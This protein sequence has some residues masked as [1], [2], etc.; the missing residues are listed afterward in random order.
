M[1]VLPA[2]RR[3]KANRTC[4]REVW[5]RPAGLVCEVATTGEGA[6]PAALTP[7]ASVPLTMNPVS[8][9]MLAT[10]SYFG[11]FLSVM[12]LAL[13]AIAR[14]DPD[15]SVPPRMTPSPD[16]DDEPWPRERE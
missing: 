7:N 4:W 13:R 3:G 10:L 9:S 6:R 15:E 14:Y 2:G 8:L 11:F 1:N 12:T 5:L 16:A